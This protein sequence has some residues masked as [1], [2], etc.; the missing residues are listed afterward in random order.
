MIHL[1]GIKYADV[2]LTNHLSIKEI[3]GFSGINAPYATEVNKGIN[4]SEFVI[5][6]E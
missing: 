2:I 1:F 6:K 4:L 3:V 5:P